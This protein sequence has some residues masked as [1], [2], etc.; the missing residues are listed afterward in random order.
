MTEVGKKIWLP[1]AV[2]KYMWSVPNNTG[3]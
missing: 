2:E 3:H 1:K